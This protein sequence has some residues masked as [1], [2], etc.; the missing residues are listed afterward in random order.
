M[1]PSGRKTAQAFIWNSF[2][3]IP[4]WGIY[5]M[6]MFILKK[7]L[8]ASD[9]QIAALIALRPALSLFAP[10]WSALVH[11]RPDRLRSNI[12]IGSI[13]SHAPFFFLPW[14][15]SPWFIIGAGALF[16]MMKRGIIPAWM[17]VL[18][19]DLPRK[20]Q[21][22]TFSYGS[23]L[24]YTG[25]AVLP[26]FFGRWMDIDPGVWRILFPVTSLLSLAGVLFLVRIPS[27]K[28]SQT[29]QTEKPAPL[30]LGALFLRPWKIGFD[31]LRRRPDFTHFQI[32]FMI[33]GAGLMAMQSAIPRFCVAELNLTYTKIAIAV[34][35]CK[36][37][38]FAL[39]SRI[40]AAWMERLNIFR[41][42]GLVTVLAAVFP[43]IFLLAKFEVNLVFAAYIVYGIMQA[44]SELS[45][46]L[47]GP[48][49]SHKDDSSSFSSVNLF[50]VGIRGLFAPALGAM[51]CS[52]YGP[53]T[54][55]LFGGGLCVLASLYLILGHRRFITAHLNKA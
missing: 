6:L 33:G 53:T 42:S 44:G 5:T 8:N 55:L 26:I 22:K 20:K 28:S 1:D 39:T 14:V 30:D 51:L 47:S 3:K 41:L 34:A 49:F 2:L 38:G 27:L 25:G 23:I 18:K 45:W 46:H 9:F 40:W 31:L 52:S 24:S 16:L 54:P 15:D 10:Y 17:E 29:A 12:I 11:K 13:I 50:T 37:I 4:F 35:T 19:R 36:G 21:Q 32:G 7:D 48:T 43:V